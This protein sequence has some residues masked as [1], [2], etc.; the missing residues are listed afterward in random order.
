M[1]LKNY[2]SSVPVETTIARIEQYLIGTGLVSG[3]GK[4]Y[5]DKVTVGVVFQIEYEAGKFPLTIRL[6]AKV[7]ECAETAR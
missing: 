5:K 4:E 3:I 6:S 2:T 7:N 1:N